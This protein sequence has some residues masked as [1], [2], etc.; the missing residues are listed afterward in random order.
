MRL[1]SFSVQKYRSITKAEK[2]PLS[3]LT[4]LVGPNNEGKSNLLQA[5]VTGMRFLVP[6]DGDG[7]NRRVG[8]QAAYAR[9]Q[10]RYSW[11]RDYPQQ[12]QERQP[13]GRSIFDFV[14]RMTEEESK[15]LEDVIGHRL[16][17]DLPVRLLFGKE[18]EPHFSVPKQR[19][20]PKISEKKDE[21]RTFV[22]ELVQVQY[23]SAVRTAE[24]A[25][26]VVD[27]LMRQELAGLTQNATY[28][29]A[30][31][32]I[33]ELERPILD[34]I[35]GTLNKSLSELL[36]EVRAVRIETRSRR[37]LRQTGD[38]RLIVDDGNP[39]D[40][41]LKGDGVQSLAAISLMRHYAAETGLS[42][43]LILAVEEPEAHLHPRGVHALRS[44]LEEISRTQQVVITTHSPLLVNRLDLASNIIVERAKARPA[45]SVRELRAVLGVRTS[46]NLDGADVVLVVE[47]TED[48]TALAA[49]LADRSKRLRAAIESGALQLVPLYG[50]GN[51]TY[52]LSLV[53]DSLCLTHAF[54]DDDP[55]GRDAAEKARAHSFLAPGDQ[56]F[57]K[58]LGQKDSEIEDLYAA[59][60]YRAAVL[61]RFNVDCSMSVGKAKSLKWSDRMR[62]RFE[63]SGQQWDSETEA[64]LK[65]VVGQAVASDPKNALAPV[66]EA[67]MESLS[68]GLERKLTAARV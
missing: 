65:A 11:S 10:G 33:D 41:A 12:L 29:A 61:E 16:N 4:V 44:V 53:R 60:V 56:T 46:D 63:S 31:K 28:A 45:E 47:G 7:Y 66:A 67:V 35:A 37:M 51:L 42:E 24:S 18:T 62:L 68:S 23:I 21:I 1:I 36:P 34:A 54:L 17:Q 8:P 49:I 2:L 64:A 5:L 20:G 32:R 22:A 48:R 19:S 57:A 3:D 59:D 27:N 14:F 52:I 39:T 26:E 50:S 58:R 43:S 9:S 6:Q 25:L 13:S 15:K 55:A 38:T 40:L 30:L